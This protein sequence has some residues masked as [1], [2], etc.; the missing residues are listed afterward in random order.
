MKVLQHYVTDE[1]VAELAADSGVEVQA[2]KL[3]MLFA[4]ADASGR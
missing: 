2:S 3:E 4:V 1:Q